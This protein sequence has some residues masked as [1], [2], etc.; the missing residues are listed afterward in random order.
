MR[1]K[2][3][4]ESKEFN[5]DMSELISLLRKNK[6]RHEVRHHP[7]A[8]DHAKALIG[9]NITGEWQILIGKVSVIRGYVSFGEY[10]AYL[11]KYKD[12]ERFETAQ[13]FLKDY[14]KRYKLKIKLC[15]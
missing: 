2:K 3:E 12:P 14:I 10:E 13:D 5:D 8:N 4:L 11:G 6:I 15:E 7:G 9:Y 1:T